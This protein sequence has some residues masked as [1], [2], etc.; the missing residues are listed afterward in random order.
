MPNRF[1][2]MFSHLTHITNKDQRNINQD[3]HLVSIR[4]ILH[5]NLKATCHFKSKFF[6]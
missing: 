4:L 1:A 5:S 3:S 2:S 6:L